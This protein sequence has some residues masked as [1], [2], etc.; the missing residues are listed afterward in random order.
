S[1]P[2]YLARARSAP[3][4]LPRHHGELRS[5]FHAHLLPGVTS[6]RVRQKQRDFANVGRLERW[7]EPLGTWADLLAGRHALTPFTA[8]AWKLA[9][10]NHPHDSICGCSI[11]Q[12]HRDMEHRFDQVEQIVGEVAR[13]GLAAIA[14][15][16]D[17][18]TDGGAAL[19]VFNPNAAGSVVVEAEAP[20]TPAL[21]ATDGST[22]P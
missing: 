19:V 8:L 4:P 14:A 1:L 16:T 12:V 15:E 7:A 17:T 11:D 6:A 20:D 18:R 5:A 13:A 22:V 10:A 3:G 9:L 21:R 2:D